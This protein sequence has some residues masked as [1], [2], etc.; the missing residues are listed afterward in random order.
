MISCVLFQD[1]FLGLCSVLFLDLELCVYL[2]SELLELYLLLSSLLDG[3]LG[4]AW[5]LHVVFAGVSGV[6]NEMSIGP[7]ACM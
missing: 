2:Y 1:W 4:L 6:L 5:G 7:S 3:V